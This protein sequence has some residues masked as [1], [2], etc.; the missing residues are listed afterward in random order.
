MSVD[1][2]TGTTVTIP[3]VG[4]T[5]TVVYSGSFAAH[6]VTQRG[7]LRL[8]DSSGGGSYTL[9]R[10]GS[11]YTGGR[12]PTPLRTAAS[13]PYTCT[14]QALQVFA[15]GGTSEQLIRGAPLP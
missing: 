4:V 15:P 6:Y 3:L 5:W 14:A 2:G 1:Y 11:Y 8:R 9:L 10:N 13:E 12:L 7:A